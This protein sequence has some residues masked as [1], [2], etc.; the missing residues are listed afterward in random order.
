MNNPRTRT[1]TF[2]ACLILDLMRPLV[3]C[4][5]PLTHASNCITS[6]PA[7]ATETRAIV[8][9]DM[10]PQGNFMLDATPSTTLPISGLGDQLR[11]CLLA[12]PEADN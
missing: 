6:R 11:I 7:A 5:S 2:Y 3:N 1:H 12:Y 10:H 8:S 4:W 9:P